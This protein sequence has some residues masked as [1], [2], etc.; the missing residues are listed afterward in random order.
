MRKTLHLANQS[1]P[2][3]AAAIRAIQ[4]ELL[5]HVFW[6]AFT[7]PLLVDLLTRY[8]H[9][10]PRLGLRPTHFRKT[11]SWESRNPDLYNFEAYFRDPK[12]TGWHGISWRKCFDPPTYLDEARQHLRKLVGPTVAIARGPC[13]ER[14]GSTDN[15]EVD[16]LKPTF[17]EMFLASAALFASK[18]NDQW[19]YYDW[20]ANERFEL[21]PT[22]P[23]VV[24][25]M[26]QHRSATLQTLCRE[27]HAEKTRG[28]AS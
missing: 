9:A 6:E 19:A 13:C 1:F 27:H 18:E 24:E 14:C 8:H 17:E 4:A 28:G 23:V 2:S 20:I 12:L 16:H 3:K 22:H 5:L 15:L 25:F 26:R 21:P 7:S 10:L 11:P